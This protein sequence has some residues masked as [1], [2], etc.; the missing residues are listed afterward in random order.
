VLALASLAAGVY[1]GSRHEATERAIATRFVRAWASG[2]VG[3]MYAELTPQA[4][5]ATSLARFR[6]AYERAADTATLEGVRAAGPLVEGAENVFD[7]RMRAR[8]RVFGDLPGRLRIPVTGTDDEPGVAWDRTMVFPGLRAGER[9]S[10]DVTMPPRATIQARDGTVIAEGPDRTSPSAVAPEVRGSIGPIPTEDA[11]TYAGLGYPPNAQVGLSGLERQ[12]E[13]RLAGTFGGTLRAGRR[14]LAT[15][16]PKRGGSVRTSIDLDV[17]A[18]SVTALAG[19]FGGIAVLRPRTG[20]VL[21]LA[22][23]GYSAPQPPGSTFKIVT[24][25]GALDA[26]VVKP[27]ASFPVLTETALS[28][29]TLQNANGESCGGSLAV[30]FAHSCNTVFAP[31][32]A[33]LGAKRLVAAAERFGFNEES[34]VIGAP[35]G[36]IPSAAEIGDDLAVGSSA[37]GQGLVTA[38]PLRMATVAAT[39]ANRGVLVRPTFLRGDDGRRTRATSPATARTIKKYMRLVVQDGTGGAA[40]IPGVKVAGKTGTAELRNTVPDPTATPDPTQPP[41][42]DKSDTDAWFVAFAPAGHPKVAV[43]VLLVGA[44]AGGESAAPA[45]RV[46]LEA[47]LKKG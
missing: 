24:L 9:L 13:R 42:D 43:A 12:F 28:G 16:E 18:A 1:A 10:R 19:R 34:D 46:V 6:R 11:E 5:R 15:A 20:E 40:A 22:G 21:G 7:V 33:K 41:A 27:S 4:R 25:A 45:A 14:R 47:A 38:T 30:S 8:T 3:A 29:V 39:I 32:G 31:L 17:V 23:I 37:I 44:G 2:D 26:K 36:S 35:P